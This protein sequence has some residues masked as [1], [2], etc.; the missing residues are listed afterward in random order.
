MDRRYQS[1]S[2]NDTCVTSD[3]GRISY[4]PPPPSAFLEWAQRRATSLTLQAQFP[5]NSRV[6]WRIIGQWTTISVVEERLK[7]NILRIG[8]IDICKRAIQPRRRNSHYSHTG[9]LGHLCCRRCIKESVTQL[10]PIQSKQGRTRSRDPDSFTGI[11]FNKYP[12]LMD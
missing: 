11:E 2:R 1:A 6:N 3:A 9:S 4:A 12:S 5:G 7:G 8:R 10:K